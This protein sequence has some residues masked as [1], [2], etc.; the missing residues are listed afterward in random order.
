MEL[1]GTLHFFFETGTEEGYW[2]FQDN[3]YKSLVSPSY[4]VTNNDK[5]YDHLDKSKIGITCNC[6]L[7]VND[8]WQLYPDS[9]ITEQDLTRVTVKWNN[10]EIEHQRKSDTLLI[11]KW[12]YQ[13]LHILKNNNILII[14]SPEDNSKVWSG[15]ID[16]KQHELFAEHSNGF[17]I[18]ADQKGIDRKKWAEYFFNKFPAELTISQKIEI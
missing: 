4:G 18:H 2:A 6:E 12:D 9:K 16:L 10:G 7:F 1:E 3:N 15:M 14:K 8:Q 17:W 13:G 11:E 5:V